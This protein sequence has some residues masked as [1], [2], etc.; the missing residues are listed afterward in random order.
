TRPACPVR[1]SAT[2]TRGRQESGSPKRSASGTFGRAGPGGQARD[3][4]ARRAARCVMARIGTHPNP[5]TPAAIVHHYVRPLTPPGR[6]PP[7][8]AR[9][10]ALHMLKRG[11]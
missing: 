11:G 8:L 5:K 3:L 6:S 1:P 2:L 4:P 10:I 7:T 9:T